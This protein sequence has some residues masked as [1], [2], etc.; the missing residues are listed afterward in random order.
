MARNGVTWKWLT[1]GKACKTDPA[2]VGVGYALRYRRRASG[3]IFADLRAKVGPGAWKTWPLGEVPTEAAMAARFPRVQITTR[4]GKVID[5]GAAHVRVEL[6]LDP[7]RERA[8]KLHAQLASG[9]DPREGTRSANTFGAVADLYLERRASQLAPRTQYEYRRAIEKIMKP[10]WGSKPIASITGRDIDELLEHVTDTRGPVAAN[11]TLLVCKAVFTWAKRKHKIA[12]SPAAGI[13]NPNEEKERQRRLSDGEL[14]RLWAV[15]ETLGY[16]YGAWAKLMLLTG[17]RNREAREA[18]WDDIDLDGGLWTVQ[19]KGDRP[20]VVPLCPMALDLLRSLPRKGDFVFTS[21]T[22]RA[23]R[24]IQDASGI[25]AKIDELAPGIPHWTFH[26][27]RRTLRSGLSRRG[28][29][30]HVAELVIGHTPGKLHRTY[31]TYDYL[32]DKRDALMRWEGHLAALI[33][34]AGN[35]VVPLRA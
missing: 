34:P 8:R 33:A 4:D 31:D 24:P 11:R 27:L 22:D 9:H 7:I 19:Q 20:H 26:D 28:V 30:P 16:P 32:P 35:N 25:K 1:G 21:G 5:G 23:P 17:T 3:R 12:A 2:C 10:R 29:P 6:A 14:R 18:R 15:F 13:E